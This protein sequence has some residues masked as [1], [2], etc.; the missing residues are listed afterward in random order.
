MPRNRPKPT[1]PSPP[2]VSD[3]FVAVGWIRGPHGIRGELKVSTLTDFPERFEAG[4][5]LWANGARY[6]VSGVRPHRGGLLVELEGI[7]VREQAEALS[8]A[9]FEV[10]EQELASLADGQHFRFQIIGMEVVDGEGHALG[11]VSDVLDTGAND[12]YIARNDEGD[13]LIPA[14]DSVV[15]EIDHE[16]G[17][18]VVELL[19]GLERRPHTRA[20]RREP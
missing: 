20:K 6:R 10:P 1:P 12:V 16:A 13:L 18:I 2:E 7:E 17:R 15:K 14:I 8:G 9:L 19:E 11:R 4:S 3:G 5:D